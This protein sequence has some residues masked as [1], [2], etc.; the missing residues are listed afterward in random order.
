[1]K[2]TGDILRRAANLLQRYADGDGPDVPRFV[3]RM[4]RP[5]SYLFADWFAKQ[6]ATEDSNG[7]HREAPVGDWHGA[8]R[9]AQTILREEP[10]RA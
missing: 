6:A 9:L 2:T 8:L 10:S 3:A 5:T 7:Y 4:D 1:M